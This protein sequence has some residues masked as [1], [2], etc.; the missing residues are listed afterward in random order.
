MSD[1]TYAEGVTETG[2]MDKLTHAIAADGSVRV[3]SAITT[4]IT[5]EA[6]RRHQTSPT[7]SAALGRMLTGTLLLGS[8]LKEFDRLTAR[9]DCRGPVEGIV[10]ES[11]KEGTVRGYVKNPIAE[12]PARDDGKFNVSGIVGEGTFYVVR[13][14]GFDIGFRPDPYIGSVPIVSGEIAEDFAYY[15]AKSE[16]IPSAVLLGVLLQNAEPYVTAAGG[17]MVQMMPGANEHIIT[18]IEDT[19]R[20]APHVTSVIKEGAQP[21]DLI[22]MALGIIDYEILE[23]KE[24]SFAC[25]CSQEKAF[26]MV[27]ALGKEEVAAMLAEDKGAVMT[28]G[29]CNETYR[30]D[31]EDLRKI[32]DSPAGGR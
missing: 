9:I 13:E 23:E 1:L 21:K 15:L 31:E 26:A 30:L 19:I 7:V 25:T 24:V 8:T 5:T 4:G 16:Q 20:H 17:L 22:E 18:M 29:F 6:V 2:F 32:L 27:A 28:C 14:T 11:T 10:A 3:L 12:L